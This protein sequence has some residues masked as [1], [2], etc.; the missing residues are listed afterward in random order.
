MYIKCID[1]N[2][3]MH[4]ISYIL[5]DSQNIIILSLKE[6]ITKIQQNSER[7]VQDMQFGCIRYLNV[8]YTGHWDE[9]FNTF[10]LDRDLIPSIHFNVSLSVTQRSLTADLFILIKP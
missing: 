8:A 1:E 6:V 3:T 4:D 10:L 5:I 9:N 7:V 2:D